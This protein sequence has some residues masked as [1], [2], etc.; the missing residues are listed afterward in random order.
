MTSLK[1]LKLCLSKGF[2][3]GLNPAMLYSAVEQEL[4]DGSVD[5]P[6]HLNMKFYTIARTQT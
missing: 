4:L 5:S 6:C 3:K 1:I 2:W